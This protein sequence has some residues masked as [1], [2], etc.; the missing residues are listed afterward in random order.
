MKTV[1]LQ[2]LAR[3]VL[4]SVPPERFFSDSERRTLLAAAE[5]LLEGSPVEITPAEVVKNVED[6]LIDG[7]SRRAWRIRVLAE[8]LEF[9][10]LLAGYRRK[11]SRLSPEERRSLMTEKFIHGRYLWAV[12]S[13]IRPLIYLGVYGDPRAERAVGFMPWH[14]R[15]R[16]K[17]AKRSDAAAGAPHRVRERKKP[18]AEPGELTL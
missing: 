14:E 6:F 11:F 10:P 18:G 12:C 3:L 17:K 15:P 13:K 16:Y 4:P 5:V 9:A 1:T 2:D 8:I 7:R